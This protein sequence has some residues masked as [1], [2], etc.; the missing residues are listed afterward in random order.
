GTLADEQDDD[1]GFQHLANVVQHPHPAML[2][3]ERCAHAPP[4]GLGTLLES[5]QQSAHVGFHSG[6]TQTIADDELDVWRRGGLGLYGLLGGVAEVPTEVGTQQIFVLAAG[7]VGVYGE[8]V[9]L[10]KHALI[11]IAPEG[12]LRNGVIPRHSSSAKVL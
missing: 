4:S 5:R 7:D 12:V 11:D 2:D 10:I 6:S 9:K 3:E 1:I 8:E